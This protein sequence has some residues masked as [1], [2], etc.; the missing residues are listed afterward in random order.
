ME[1]VMKNAS[2][3]N[4]KW[5][6]IKSGVGFSEVSLILPI[7]QTNGQSE[8]FLETGVKVYN[9]DLIDEEFLWSSQDIILFSSLFGHTLNKNAPVTIELNLADPSVIE[10]INIVASARFSED[11]DLRQIDMSPSFQTQIKNIR[12]GE[13]VSIN[14]DQGFKLAVVAGI[15]PSDLRCVI[16][17]PFFKP[18]SNEYISIHDVIKISKIG[19]LP[20]EFGANLSCN[21][22]ILH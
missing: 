20:A 5:R 12:L 16:L 7:M 21:S 9:L 10:I 19:V 1:V 2:P 11:I 13:V 18:E 22:D 4:L 3:V 14:T 17:E 15:T 6:I 8:F